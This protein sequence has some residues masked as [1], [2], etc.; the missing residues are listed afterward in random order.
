MR[1]HCTR[2]VSAGSGLPSV[3]HLQ[4]GHFLAEARADPGAGFPSSARLPLGHSRAPGESRSRELPDVFRTASARLRGA[5]PRA[6]TFLQGAA[7]AARRPGQRGQ[8]LASLRL[9]IR[10]GA[11]TGGAARLPTDGA[12]PVRSGAATGRRRLVRAGCRA[13]EAHWAPFRPPGP[14]RAAH[15][16]VAEVLQRP[17]VHRASQT[18][19]QL[20]RRAHT[21]HRQRRGVGLPYKPSSPVASNALRTGGKSGAARVGWRAGSLRHP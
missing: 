1:A 17:E 4:Y 9:A 15:T 2:G 19:L 7:R 21:S 10:R 8:G 3:Q 11:G 14:T 5:C 20:R 13:C 18:H 6:G 12:F 16:W